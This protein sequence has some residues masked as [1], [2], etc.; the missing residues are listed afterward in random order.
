VRF[1]LLDASTALLAAT[2]PD[3][4]R[5]SGGSTPIADGQLRLTLPPYAVLTFGADAA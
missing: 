3:T 1:R 5:R 4:F 2:D